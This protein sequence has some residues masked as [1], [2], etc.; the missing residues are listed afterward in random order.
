M[1]TLNQQVT[2]SIPVRL[3]FKFPLFANTCQHAFPTLLHTEHLH[4]LIADD[5]LDALRRHLLQAGDDMAVRV[6]GHGDRAVAEPF[7]DDLGV[8]SV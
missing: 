8:Y 3:R 4:G 2:G 6:D 5:V 7:L 1:L